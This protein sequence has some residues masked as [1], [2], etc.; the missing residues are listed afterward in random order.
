MGAF[1]LGRLVIH[2]CNA[3][4]PLVNRTPSLT[5]P[6]QERLLQRAPGG[7]SRAFFMPATADTGVSTW[8]TWLD[9]VGGGEIPWPEGVKSDL[10]PVLPREVVMD[11][12]SQHVK[13][14]K[15]CRAALRWTERLAAAAGAV[16]AV[17]APVGVLALLL[18]AAAAAA[19]S[20][21]AAAAAA[22]KA[23]AAAAKAAAPEAA[24][25]SLA[26]ALLGW[27]MLVIAALA[28]LA[29][30]RLLDLRRRFYFTDYVHA[31]VP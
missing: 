19:A 14:C 10:G 11:R 30:R 2:V 3:L 20:S 27:P 5:P 22:T 29:R 25:N 28:L 15:S 26:T 9:R 17:A 12:F 8:R 7:W 13:G 23:A 18:R 4:R 1:V 21:G 24:T 6:Q 16:A 31:A